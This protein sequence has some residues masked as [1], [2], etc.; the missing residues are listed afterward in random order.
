MVKSRFTVLKYFYVYRRQ[1][2]LLLAYAVTIHK[3]QGLLL[4]CAIVDLSDRVFSAGMAYVALSRV[5]SLSGL[6]L[7]AFDPKSIMVSPRCLKEVNRLRETYRTD[8][9]LYELPVEHRASGK[10]KLT[11]SVQPNQPEAKKRKGNIDTPSKALPTKSKRPGELD[12]KA[13]KKTCSGNDFEPRFQQAHLDSIQA[14]NNGRET[15]APL[16][17][18]SFM[19]KTK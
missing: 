8:L 15:P 6:Y 4:N 5:R 2:L 19:G 1:F 7:S 14:M 9:P 17:V 13:A 16:W 12:E 18:F 11:G 3:C 10:R